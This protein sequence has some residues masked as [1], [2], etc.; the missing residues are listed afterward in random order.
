MYI[1]NITV[2]YKVTYSYNSW[3]IILYR[4]NKKEKQKTVVSSTA[5]VNDGQMDDLY[6]LV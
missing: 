6:E 5:H 4:K 3:Y 2:L 1:S